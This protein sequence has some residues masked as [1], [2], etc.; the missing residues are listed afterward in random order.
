[1]KN[2]DHKDIESYVCI[3]LLAKE[4]D[5]IITITNATVASTTMEIVPIEYSDEVFYFAAG[6]LGAHWINVSAPNYEEKE[7]E[8]KLTQTAQNLDIYL[9]S[10]GEKPNSMKQSM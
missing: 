7:L 5:Q 10:T 8:L 9:D 3:K 4:N 1:M 6:N 2:K